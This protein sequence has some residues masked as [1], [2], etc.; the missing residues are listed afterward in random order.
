MTVDIL[1]VPAAPLV[2]LGVRIGELA[3][4]RGEQVAVVCEGTVRTWT[5]LESRTNRLA[6][7]LAD[8]GVS[9]G[10]LVTIGLPNSVEF[11]EAAIACWKLGA[12]PQ[13]VSAALPAAELAAII[14]LADPPLVIAAAGVAADRPVVG[15]AELLAAVQDDSA[16]PPVI[17]PAW[18]APTS[19]GSTGRPKLIVT[20]QPGVV[21]A[22]GTALWRHTTDGVALMP[23]PLYHNGPFASGLQGLL[24]GSKLLLQRRFDAEETL[25]LIEEHQVTWVYLVPAMMRRIWSLPDEVK[26][27]YDL[28]SLVTVWHLA[29][30]C[31]EWLKQAWIDWLGP[32]CLWELYAGTESQAGT[33]IN[34]VDWL[35]HRGSV[36]QVFYG[37]MTVLD[38]DGNPA[39]AGETG[40]I[41]LRRT[42]G[43]GP[44]YHYIGAEPRTRGD[45]ESLGDAGWMDAD[46]FLFL[47]DRLSDLIL[48][49]G[50]NVYP[51]EVEGALDE[52]PQVAS[53]AVVGLPDD[54][55]G[56]V[57][58]AI[59]QGLPGLDLEDLKRHLNER[60]VRYKQPR[61]FELVDYPLRDEAGKIRRSQLRKEC[62]AA[63][64][65]ASGAVSS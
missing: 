51:A 53:S 28:S 42:P 45:W 3:Q 31:P 49:G 44:A 56:E 12:V 43:M 25:R 48:V 64:T 37:E 62:I 30:P 54:D 32:D 5:E 4:Q 57:P 38:D 63:R 2:P 41:F 10:R 15:I 16:L 50:S 21:D 58:H 60:L 27:R 46:G 59:I 65:V 14:E 39:A 55:L 22:F 19:G 7:A 9:L 24:H 23:G 1:N 8:R 20:G 33:V 47:A 13:P 11:V 26:A 40:E 34:G 35:T 29:A 17:S 52:H 61:S 6:R 18:K 36:G